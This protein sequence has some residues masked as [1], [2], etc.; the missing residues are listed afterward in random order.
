MAKL[1]RIRPAKRRR[2]LKEAEQDTTTALGDFYA[3]EHRVGEA[4]EEERKRVT[5]GGSGKLPC[6]QCAFWK[7]MRLKHETHVSGRCTCASEF[8]HLARKGVCIFHPSRW[9][10]KETGA[11]EIL[12]NGKRNP[13]YL[14]K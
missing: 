12:R 1:K 4:I 14:T 3:Q 2:L 9:H 11:P 7:V 5:Y 6:T 8:P 10:D 13:K